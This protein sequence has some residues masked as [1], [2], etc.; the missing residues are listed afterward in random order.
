MGLLILR[1]SLCIWLPTFG[2]FF[3]RWIHSH[4]DCLDPFLGGKNVYH[5]EH[6]ARKFS[7]KSEVMSSS[8]SCDLSVVGFGQN[9]A[10]RTR[11]SGSAEKLLARHRALFLRVDHVFLAEDRPGFW[12]ALPNVIIWSIR[13]KRRFFLAFPVGGPF[14]S[15][16]GKQVITR[17]GSKL[18]SAWDACVFF[19][20]YNGDDDT[21]LW[22]ARG[23]KWFRT[24]E[25]RFFDRF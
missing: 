10:N 3:C 11:E 7:G 13:I 8:S 5:T 25:G 18:G 22:H 19:W 21:T 24:V 23:N 15:A 16:E 2:F 6:S 20:F 9:P 17:L 12:R 4:P 14:C 1:I